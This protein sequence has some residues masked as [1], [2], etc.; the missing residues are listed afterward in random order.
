MISIPK[1]GSQVLVTTKHKNV[2]LGGSP[3]KLNQYRGT[4]LES[5]KWMNSHE[6]MIATDDPSR[7]KAIINASYVS[8]VKYLKGS[9][10]VVNSLTRKFKVTSKSS[11][12]DYIV[13][14][15]PGKVHCT[16]TGFEYRKYCKHSQAVSKKVSGEKHGN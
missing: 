8:D 11:G 7:P 5:A 4:V 14:V 6:F 1:V 3:F 13:T 15:S 9:G 2:I 10:Q 16:C 12:K